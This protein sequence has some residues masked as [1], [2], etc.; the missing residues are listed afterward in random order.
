[1]KTVEMVLM[2]TVMMMMITVMIARQISIL[3]FSY[4]NWILRIDV[5]PI[6]R[7]D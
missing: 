6:Y 5:A 3:L 7:E 2:I 1:M 4:S